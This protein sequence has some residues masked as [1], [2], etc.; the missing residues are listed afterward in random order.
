LFSSAPNISRDVE[1]R[2]E[3]DKPQ[4]KKI[5]KGIDFF[6]EWAEPVLEEEAE[7]RHEKA[8]HEVDDQGGHFLHF[9]DVDILRPVFVILFWK[10]LLHISLHYLVS[11]LQHEVFLRLLLFCS[12]NTFICYFIT[13][14]KISQSI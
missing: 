9:V 6:P 11:E 10:L 3:E 2:K 13:L 14:E 8:S 1:K 7:T 5:E 12:G 4:K